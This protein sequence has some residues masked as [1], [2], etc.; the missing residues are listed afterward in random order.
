M[1]DRTVAISDLDLEFGAARADATG[2]GT[3]R[4]VGL[5]DYFC[6]EEADTG[7]LP[8][9][10]GG[11]VGIENLVEY[12]LL[13]AARIIGDGHHGP[14]VFRPGAHRYQRPGHGTLKKGIP[15][16]HQQTTAYQLQIFKT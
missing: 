4:H 8:E 13:D 6:H 7:P 9:L 1:C 15:G 3:T 10:L 14:A 16:I 5:D 2:G 12:L 11:E